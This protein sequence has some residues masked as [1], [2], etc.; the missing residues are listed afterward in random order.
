MQRRHNHKLATSDKMY[1]STSLYSVPSTKKDDIDN[2]AAIFPAS[3][4]GPMNE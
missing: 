3:L 2:D 1:K 4:I